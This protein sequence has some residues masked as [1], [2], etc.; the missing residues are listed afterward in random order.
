MADS[1]ALARGQIAHQ[2]EW[3]K[4]NARIGARVAVVNDLLAERRQ[5]LERL[6]DLYFAAG[7]ERNCLTECKIRLEAMVTALRKEKPGPV[8]QPEAENSPLVRS[9]VL[10]FAVKAFDGL[11]LA[12]VDIAK[13]RSLIKDMGLLATLTIEDGQRVAYAYCVVS[14]KKMLIADLRCI[15]QHN[16]QPPFALTA[17]LVL[18][19][20][21]RWQKR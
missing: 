3:E 6:L 2:A 18:G 11:A 5:R 4:E 12:V 17:R 10:A 20:V 15:R 21:S 7:F 1:P 19:S 14:N 8:A 13:R 9:K 16:S